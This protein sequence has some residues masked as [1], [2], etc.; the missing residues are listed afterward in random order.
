MAKLFIILD[1]LLQNFWRRKKRPVWLWRKSSRKTRTSGCTRRRWLPMGACI[2][3]WW[4]LI[5]KFLF[6]F[7]SG[8]EKRWKSNGST[9]SS[10]CS[11]FSIRSPSPSS[12]TISPTGSPS[13]CV[14]PLNS[15]GCPLGPA[16]KS[17]CYTW[18]E[19]WIRKQLTNRRHPP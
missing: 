14:S 4:R 13:S 18:M 10:S 7:D 12:I 2:W 3:L 6:R 15:R 11:S 19:V 17:L 16:L 5:S 9:G 1:P 8:L